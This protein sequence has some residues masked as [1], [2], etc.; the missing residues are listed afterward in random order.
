MKLALS[1]LVL[2]CAT[3]FGQLAPVIV[4]DEAKPSD[5]SMS[6]DVAV[7]RFIPKNGVRDA[8]AGF[9]KARDV[10]ELIEA[11]N[12]TGAGDEMFRGVRTLTGWPQQAA[13]FN[14]I[15]H[16]PA[17]RLAGSNDKVQY[18]SFGLNLTV[19]AAAGLDSA[20]PSLTWQGTYSWST[21]FIPR[22]IWETVLMGVMNAGKVVGA[23]FEEKDQSESVGLRREGNQAVG[24]DLLSLFGRKKVKA[25]ETAA[26]VAAAAVPAAE[27]QTY[28][29]AVRAEA[30]LAGETEM[31]PGQFAI[32]PINPGDSAA[33]DFFLAIRCDWE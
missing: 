18:H 22:D 33:E 29:D 23:S 10:A 1:I 32:I 7:L 26:P 20:N 15:E 30:K 3:A 9:A 13:K 31:K 16:R 12:K 17:F 24:K 4:L 5:R 11:M 19:G 27:P 6:I 28:L 14:C 8:T 2:F 25:K 21:N